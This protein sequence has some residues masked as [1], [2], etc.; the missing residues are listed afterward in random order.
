[1]G[2]AGRLLG[3]CLD[4]GF[5]VADTTEVTTGWVFLSGK[6]RTDFFRL[7]APHKTFSFSENRRDSPWGLVT[8]EEARRSSFFY[9]NKFCSL[10][11]LYMYVIQSG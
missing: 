9:I 10:T 4:T 6:L 3:S 8:G 1:M 11:I 5:L 2:V 7:P